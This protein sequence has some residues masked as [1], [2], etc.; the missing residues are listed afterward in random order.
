MLISGLIPATAGTIEVGGAPVQG[1]VGNIADRLSARR[2]AR[3]AHGARQCAAAGRDQEARPREPPP[4]G[5]RSP[6]L[7]RAC[8]IRGQIS[9]RALR[10]HAPAGGDLPG[11]GAGP[12][13]AADGRA[14]RRARRAH[15][16]AD[17]PRSAAHVAARP[18]HR[19]L[20][21]PQHRGGGAAVRPRGGDVV[22]PGAHR[23]Y[24]ARTICRARAAPTPAARRASSST[25]SASAGISWRW[26]CSRRREEML[27][28]GAG[29]CGP[30]LAKTRRMV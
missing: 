3:L 17:E 7:G 5:A 1:A 12:R 25:S 30:N 14:V 26:A 22:A 19:A 29:V 4:Q 2:P 18:Q 23:R 11:A 9:G 6:A 21:H 13:P 27:G 28:A 16:R 15:P 24:R 20:H 8:R 10:R